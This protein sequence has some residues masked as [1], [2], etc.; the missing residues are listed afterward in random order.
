MRSDDDGRSRVYLVCMCVCVS[1]TTPLSSNI[2]GVQARTSSLI[3]HP[4]LQTRF[5]PP[6]AIPRIREPVPA[7][8][9]SVDVAPARA[10]GRQD[11]PTVAVAVPIAIAIAIAVGVREAVTVILLF[12]FPCT[13]GQRPADGLLLDH[14]DHPHARLVVRAEQRRAGQP[15]RVAQLLASVALEGGRVRADAGAVGEVVWR[16]VAVRC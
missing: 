3:H 8:T 9:M 4:L 5:R 11:T 16:A 10:L 13:R 12:E 6:V 14:D 1:S 15:A 7:N 2:L